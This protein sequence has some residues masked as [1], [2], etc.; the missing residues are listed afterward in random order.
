M[1]HDIELE[2]HTRPT[3]GT[4]VA[5]V[6]RRLSIELI[7]KRTGNFHDHTI[8]GRPDSSMTV[9]PPGALAWCSH[10]EEVWNRVEWAERHGRQ[11]VFFELRTAV[12]DNLDKV[13]RHDFA[14]NLAGFIARDMSVPVT[15]AV[16][17]GAGPWPVRDDPARQVRLCFPTRMLALADY[18]NAIRDRSNEPSGFAGRLAMTTNPHLAKQFTTRVTQEVG[19][20]RHAAGSTLPNGKTRPFLPDDG[21]LFDDLPQPAAVPF[22]N[23][24][25]HPLLV[26]LRKEAP[27]GMTLPDLR[28]FELAMGFAR[29]VEEALGDV[30]AHGKVDD[31]LRGQLARVSTSVLDHAYCLDEARRYRARVDR[32][33]KE[34]KPLKKSFFVFL[35]GRMELASLARQRKIDEQSRA[36]LHVTELKAAASR[37]RLQVSKLKLDCRVSDLALST[38]RNELKD[39]VKGLHG[40]D[41]R[42]LQHMLVIAGDEER[43]QMKLAMASVIPKVAEPSEASSG[44]GGHTG[45][46]IKPARGS[47]PG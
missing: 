12:P 44:D 28:D 33:L 8:R 40:A 29:T 46:P 22:E 16:L 7:D 9:A 2:L 11:P 20:L 21:D 15:F 19:R 41:P 14:R 31:N 43:V 3:D 47:R 36:S 10:A 5:L 18:S 30:V 23:P 32:E 37:L 45:P 34:M 13:E 1:T 35:R 27:R 6:A 24:E 39:A 38:A 26:R 17:E 42:I 4:A 25:T